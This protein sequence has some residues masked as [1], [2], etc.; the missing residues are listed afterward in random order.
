MCLRNLSKLKTWEINSINLWLEMAL[1]HVDLVCL[2]E[3]II[4]VIASHCGTIAGAET[5]WG[6][7]SN[8]GKPGQMTM[9][10]TGGITKLPIGGFPIG[11]Q[12]KY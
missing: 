12:A 4:L 5:V 10:N 1:I 6:E 2:R 11:N 8:D 7:G 3:G 9:Q